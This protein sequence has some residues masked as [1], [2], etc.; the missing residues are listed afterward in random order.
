[1]VVTASVTGDIVSITAVEV[2]VAEVVL[3]E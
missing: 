1:V 3:P 2:E